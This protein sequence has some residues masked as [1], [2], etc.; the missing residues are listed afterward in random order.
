MIPSQIKI[1]SLAQIILK[2]KA[3]LKS[4]HDSDVAITDLT[5]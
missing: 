1:G 2:S 4:K 3:P 5:V